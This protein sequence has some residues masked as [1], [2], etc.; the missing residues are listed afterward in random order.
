MSEHVEYVAQMDWA[1]D[2]LSA[3]RPTEK[4]NSVQKLAALT[5]LASF[6]QVHGYSGL[7]YNSVTLKI[8][9]TRLH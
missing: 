4:Q 9:S 2:S 6:V 8:P 5:L 3:Q 1:P 7:K